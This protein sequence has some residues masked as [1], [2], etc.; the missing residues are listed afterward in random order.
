M[1]MEIKVR[2]QACREH[3]PTV[4]TLAISTNN[5]PVGERKESVR[6]AFSTFW[7]NFAYIFIFRDTTFQ[8]RKI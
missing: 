3:R 8:T 1:D 7:R 2:S 4:S 5:V 6:F